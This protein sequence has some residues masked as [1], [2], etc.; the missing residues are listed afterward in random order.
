MQDAEQVVCD[1]QH[2]AHP[3]GPREDKGQ[4]AELQ[5][6]A[7]KQR[8]GMNAVSTCAAAAGTLMRMVTYQDSPCLRAGGGQGNVAA[9]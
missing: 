5:G 7:S 3:V 8:G 4:L 1:A 2:R 9:S 6:A